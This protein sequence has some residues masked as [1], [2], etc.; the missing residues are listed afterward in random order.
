MS[1]WDETVHDISSVEFET[2]K[3][4][5]E[6]VLNGI[7]V[8]ICAMLNSYG[9][10]VLIYIMSD[11]EEPFTH[12]FAVI[13]ILEQSIT[14]IIGL[15]QTVSK[16]NFEEDKQRII[17]SVT[18]IG[19]FITTNYNL[20]LPSQKQVVQVYSWESPQK[21][22][23]DIIDR[24]VVEEPVIKFQHLSQCQ[25]FIKGSNC[26]FHESK[27]VQLKNLKAEKSKRTRLSDRMTGKGNKFSCYVSAF[28]NYRGGHMYYGITSEG[29]VEGEVISN[30]DDKSD[31]MKKVEKAINKMIWPEQTG[32]PK[33]G[34]HWEIFFEPVL[35]ENSK[36]IPS[37]FVIVIH[38]A[39]C[40]G[41]VFTEEPEC[42]EMVEG[43]VEKMSF[44]SWKKRILHPLW[45]GVNDEIPPRIKRIKWSSPEERK[46]FTTGGEEFRQLIGN[47]DWDTF[48][49][50]CEVLK[51]KSKSRQVDLLVLSQKV[52]AYYR[53]GEF[54]KA[55]ENLKEYWKI[56]AK[57][58]DHLFFEALGV[59]LEA[60]LYRARKDW[61]A[62]K[63]KL[64]VALFLATQIEPGL[65][66]ATI[67]A[68]AGTVADQ[69]SSRTQQLSPEILSRRAL[70]HLQRVA[71]LFHINPD[72]KQ[73]AHI[74]LATY[75]LG[76]NMCEMRT[77]GVLQISNLHAASANIMA[78]HQSA[79]EGT[80]SSYYD[81]QLNL[82]HAIYKYRQ[83]QVNS[84][85]ERSRFVRNAFDFAKK[86]ERLARDCQ[87]VEMLE[88][89]KG[90]LALCTEELLRTKFAALARIKKIQ[91]V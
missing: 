67:Y 23:E 73:K 72:K 53:R 84:D 15:S 68:F 24:K 76:S 9:G 40:L 60:A 14:S 81:V 16:I 89:S 31:I 63:K 44:T 91:E 35:D 10:K 59:Y 26:G 22:L 65:I 58:P 38:I 62:L 75:Y 52:R 88:W 78:V 80:L 25:Q 71:E 64:H 27:T 34:E 51:S 12:I 20:Y 6:E 21:V 5:R 48:F 1:G 90:V 57:V 86:A 66:T 42:Y 50:K 13:R 39:P 18:K 83:S 36:P 28:A 46:V 77:K 37:T 2:N 7:L 30:D 47:G 55:F 49:K 33:R 4:Y 19:T 70:E 29:V 32:Q 87:F 11:N 85:F 69:I 56:Q 41:G 43:K 3:K 61:S 82:V 45:P 74:N 79:C 54:M 8:A 17:I